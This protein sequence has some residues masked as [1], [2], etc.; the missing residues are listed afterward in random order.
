MMS[1]VEIEAIDQ[2]GI[3]VGDEELLARPVI[4]DIAQAGA[5][6]G[7][8]GGE[9]RDVAGC[10]VDA[11]DAARR[12]A[13]APLPVHEG[14]VGLAVRDALGPA[15]AVIVGRDDLDTE[16]GGRAEIDVRRRLIV[17]GDRE[18]FADGTRR[19]REY[20]RRRNQ[21][22]GRRPVGLRPLDLHRRPVDV[23][24]RLVDRIAGRE[25]WRRCGDA[26][27]AGDDRVAG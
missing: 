9:Q 18:D 4:D 6:I 14:G 5:G 24:E 11:I 8:D 15:V 17:E 3:E 16:G 7:A 2:S 1:P 23:D 27:E 22:S 12:T 10:A 20:G 25:R 26:G 19:R 21:L 13:L